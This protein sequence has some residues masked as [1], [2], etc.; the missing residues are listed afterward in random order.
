MLTPSRDL[1]GGPAAESSMSADE[2]DGLESFRS[3]RGG[4][5]DVFDDEGLDFSERNRKSTS[6]ESI[7]DLPKGTDEENQANSSPED[8]A[9]QEQRRTK[10]TRIV[11]RCFRRRDQDSRTMEE[12]TTHLKTSLT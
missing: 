3:K 12:I 6:D 10:E 11:S 4:E 9:E 2:G 7:G 1:E 5:E 8:E